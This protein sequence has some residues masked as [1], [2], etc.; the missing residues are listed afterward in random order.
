[1]LPDLRD[2]Q[3]EPLIVPGGIREFIELA[4]GRHCLGLVLSPELIEILAR[5]LAHV[6]LFLQ[7]DDR[8]QRSP[9]T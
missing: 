6:A 2:L 3:L 5:E 1:M 4:Q 8:D 7:V 9:L